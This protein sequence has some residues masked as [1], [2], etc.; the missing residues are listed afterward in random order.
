[1]CLVGSSGPTAVDARRFEY[2]F[3][4]GQAIM[5]LVRENVRPRDIMTRQAFLNAIAVVEAVGGST[6]AVLH[7][8]AI[9]HEAGVELTLDDFDQVSRRTPHL[10]STKPSGKY[11]MDELHRVGGIPVVMKELLGAGLFDGSQPSVSGGTL[12]DHLTT[13]KLL[14]DQD[15]IQGVANPIS[16]SGT[17]AILIMALSALGETIR[18]RPMTAL[19]RGL[20]LVRGL[21][22]SARRTSLA[23]GQGPAVA[24]SAWRPLPGKR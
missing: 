21:T 22:R 1:M 5:R 24:E 6:N 11:A 8:P 13:A 9:A 18:G 14:P 23:A 20:G 16:P 10:A 19:A 7:L 15:V 2:G 17:L 12:A 3:K 4:T